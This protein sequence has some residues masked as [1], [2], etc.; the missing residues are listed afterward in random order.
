VL[1]TERSSLRTRLFQE[2]AP[3]V[4]A[5]CLIVQAVCQSV[6]LST[7]PSICVC[8]SICLSILLPICPFA[9]ICVRVFLWLA[10]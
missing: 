9:S 5:A 1:G 2:S 10:G 6:C 8:L 7:R 3:D 4:P